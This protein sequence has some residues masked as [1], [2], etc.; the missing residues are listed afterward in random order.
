MYVG[1]FCFKMLPSV[2]FAE[3]THLQ[4]NYRVLLIIEIHEVHMI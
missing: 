2:K 3:E 1:A 4:Q